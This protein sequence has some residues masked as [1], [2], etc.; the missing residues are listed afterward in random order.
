MPLPAKKSCSDRPDA[1]GRARP[2]SLASQPSSAPRPSQ[3]SLLRH[4]RRGARCRATGPSCYHLV[5]SNRRMIANRFMARKTIFVALWTAAFFLGGAILAGIVWGVLF[6]IQLYTTSEIG[7]HTISTVSWWPILAPWVVGSI[8]FMM[9]MMGRLPG[10][11]LRLV[12]GSAV[13]L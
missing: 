13:Q 11:R 7:E 4:R 8:G 10:T 6:P 3:P 2:S 1:S 5:Q 9:G 12:R